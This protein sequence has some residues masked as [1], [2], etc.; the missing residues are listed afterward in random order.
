MRCRNPYVSNGMAYGCGQC[1]ECRVDKARIWTH[2]MM[3]EA[4]G[5]ADNAF[6]SLTYDDK[7]LPVWREGP[8]DGP[9]VLRPVLVVKDLQDWLKRIRKAVEPARLR[10]FG[11]GEYGD[12]TWR[13]HY[14]LALFGF[15]NCRW[16]KS[17]YSKITKN[18]CVNCDLIRDTWGKGNIL[19][20][21]LNVS[22]AQY[23]CGYVLKK[24]TAKDDLRL[25]GLPPEFA[26]MSLK[27]GIGAYA[28]DDVAST[29]LKFNLEATEVDVPSTLR[30][31]KRLWPLGRYL[32][33][34]LRKN[35][36]KEEAAPQVVL[37][38]IKEDLRPLREAA[39]DASRSFKKEI[40]MAADQATLNL[41][42]RRLLR[43]VR[44]D[45]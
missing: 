10:Y 6:V 27:P 3:L 8:E 31:G 11:V 35:V 18:C 42:R 21:E 20:G 32:Q 2:R 26:R 41:R 40:V 1:E 30:H 29:L 37:D 34:R 45:L 44:R 23:V 15:P 19:L 12:I 17:R 4:G 38:K 22:S 7:H 16:G 5:H 13:P 14:H 24:M 33:R 39:F 36:G 9:H 25:K 43:K 28:M